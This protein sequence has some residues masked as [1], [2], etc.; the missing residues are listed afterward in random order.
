M[1]QQAFLIAI[2]LLIANGPAFGQEQTN[3]EE[4]LHERD[5]FQR[6]HEGLSSATAFEELSEER[7]PVFDDLFVNSIEV[8]QL[9]FV[10]KTT[11]PEAK[12]P[13]E[14]KTD[15]IAS[16][17]LDLL[18]K[19][20]LQ[21]DGPKASEDN[22]HADI[23]EEL[24]RLY[25]PGVGIEDRQERA[26][27]IYEG[28]IDR[29]LDRV[30]EK[31]GS[32]AR[33]RVEQKMR[34]EYSDNTPPPALE[35]WVVPEDVEPDPIPTPLDEVPR[36]ATIVSPEPVIRTPERPLHFED[37]FRPEDR[38][39]VGGGTLDT[40]NEKMVRDLKEALD[41]HISQGE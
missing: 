31:Y 9:P 17:A 18:L 25:G 19:G 23:L 21:P 35:L 33:L 10:I 11:N 38:G 40:R 12:D 8:I 3:S 39:A 2:F 29:M 13:A 20:L 7:R 41:R 16:A 4:T 34:R 1:K 32:G 6:P 14:V 36:A 5:R 24:G 26:Q 15:S 22:V 28:W 27:A 37:R 30:E